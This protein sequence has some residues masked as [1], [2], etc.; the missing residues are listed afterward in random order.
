MSFVKSKT[1]GVAEEIYKSCGFSSSLPPLSKC[2]LPS[3]PCPN[4]SPISSSF[5]HYRIQSIS[6]HC[7]LLKRF[8]WIHSFSPTPCSCTS[9]YH[10]HV[11]P[12][13]WHNLLTGFPITT[14][15]PWKIYSPYCYQINDFYV[16]LRQCSMSCPS[17]TKSPNWLTKTP[18]INQNNSPWPTRSC[19]V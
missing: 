19:M 2:H 7:Q 17:S 5:P 3:C 9:P 11:R 10:H 1:V 14:L 13:R 8:S 12:G 18:K 15:A 6:K 16:F 4:P